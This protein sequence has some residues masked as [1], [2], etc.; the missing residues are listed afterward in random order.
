MKIIPDG[1]GRKMTAFPH[2]RIVVRHSPYKV[3]KYDYIRGYISLYF[4]VVDMMHLQEFERVA[5]IFAGNKLG[6]YKADDGFQARRN[7][8][9]AT[10]LYIMSPKIG[11]ELQEGV[12][13]FREQIG[14]VYY[15]VK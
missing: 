3:G 4:Q 9:Y 13:K 1:Q 12:Y 8:V 10:S 11:R 2:P 15:F 7:A 14:D 6:L 5:L